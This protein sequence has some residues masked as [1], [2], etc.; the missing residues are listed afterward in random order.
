M[1]HEVAPGIGIERREHCYLIP[2]LNVTDEGFANDVEIYPRPVIPRCWSTAVMLL[3]G[4]DRGIMA[5]R[6]KVL[7][8]LF[9]AGSLGTCVSKSRSLGSPS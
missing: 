7:R 5:S 6:R 2:L 4:S 9:D 3:Y 1:I 8:G